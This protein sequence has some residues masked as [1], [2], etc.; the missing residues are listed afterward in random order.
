MVLG[1]EMESRLMNELFFVLQ[2]ESV[3]L[4]PRLLLAAKKRTELGI[5]GPKLEER[6]RPGAGVPLIA[7]FVQ[8]GDVLNLYHSPFCGCETC[9]RVC[10]FRR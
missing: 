2:R 10:D 4:V 5:C 3:L 1:V 8:K 7:P 9:T 6:K